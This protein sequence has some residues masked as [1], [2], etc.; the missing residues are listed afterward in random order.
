MTRHRWMM[1]GLL[2]LL[3]ATALAAPRDY[4]AA[5]A[6]LSD[7][8][9]YY[10]KEV[11]QRVVARA[12]TSPDRKQRLEI[13]LDLRLATRNLYAF[14]AS[15]PAG[16]EAQIAATLRARLLVQATE[17]I[18]TTMDRAQNR[19]TGAQ[20]EGVAELHKLSYQ[21]IK[22]LKDV[23]DA[24]RRMA[25][26][27]VKLTGMTG[28]DESTL[29]AVRPKPMGGRVTGPRNMPALADLADD[30]NKLNVS[31][32]LRRQLV[33][34]ALKAASPGTAAGPERDKE[35]ATLT[36]LLRDALE[37]ARA[38][39]GNLGV[40]PEV[41][42][43][44]EVTLSEGIALTMD[45]RTRTLGQERMKALSAYRQSVSRI[46]GLNLSA[47]LL[48]QFSPLFAWARVNSSG[49]ATVMSAVERFLAA[50][51]RYEARPKVANPIEALRK[52]V[53]SLEKQF[54][55]AQTA[56]AVAAGEVPRNPSKVAELDAQSEEMRKAIDLLEKF[57]RMPVTLDLLGQF[58]PRPPG[59][60]ER[61]ITLAATN[62]FNPAV[63]EKNRAEG[64]A[65]IDAVSDL[66]ATVGELLK[67]D[68]AAVSPTVAR[69]CAAGK[70]PAVNDKWRALASELVN[71]LAAGKEADGRKLLQL[72]QTMELYDAVRQAGKLEAAL[73]DEGVLA[74]WVDWRMGPED[75]KAVFTGYQEAMSE[76]FTGYVAGNASA[77]ET[78]N[79]AEKRYRPVLA[80]MNRVAA[81]K[82]QCSKFPVATVNLAAALATPFDG[83]P[84]DRERFA[85]YAMEVHRQRTDAGDSSGAASILQAFFSRLGGE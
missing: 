62:L 23:D 34:L 73:M 83:A 45:A 82:D 37:L 74:R 21:E 24:G 67:F 69:K 43:Q 76:A 19:L 27:L 52:P 77:V 2:M 84:F 41:R 54:S 79:R 10:L 51:A 80:L 61:R 35:V 38:L 42:Q 29:P 58:K 20:Q 50:R 31:M 48:Q 63:N 47:D 70:L 17:A 22:S 33:A 64:R 11:T 46:V 7:L 40:T 25:V 75:L 14:A 72:S 60:L 55:T 59:A 12:E 4:V 44:M 6:M 49:S 36:Q 30:V 16:S 71:E 57:D 8:E 9:Q 53:E 56:F 65:A 18:E 78:W 15:A 5:K 68:A 28:V 13:E 85:A 81:Y 1:P 26:A 39:Q 3:S 32:G 66:A